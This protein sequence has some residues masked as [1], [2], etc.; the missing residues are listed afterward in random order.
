MAEKV[1]TLH[2]EPLPKER[3]RATVIGGHARIY[4][5]RKTVE[6]EKKIG[7][8]WKSE[9]GEEP[10]EGAVSVRIVT[11]M[12]IPKSSTK[13]KRKDMEERKT[14]PVTKPDA[15]NLAKAI[16]DGL[17]GIAFRDD[18]QIVDLSISKYY[19]QSPK[20]MVRVRDWVPETE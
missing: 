18:N 19:G 2:V 16:L 9:F 15:D 17:N 6:Y 1:L 7:A 13:Q 5:P 20:I 14:R 4:T 11:F 10:F 12:P 8:A 3:P